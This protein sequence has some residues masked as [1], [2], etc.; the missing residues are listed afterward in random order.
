MLKQVACSW[1][2][3]SGIAGEFGSAVVAGVAAEP[4]LDAAFDEGIVQ[5]ALDRPALDLAGG[6]GVAGDD[7]RR[8]A[9]NRRDLLCDEVAPVELAEIGELALHRTRADAMAEIVLAAGI[10]LEVGRER[11][12]VPGEEA[13]QPAIMVVMAMADDQ[14]IDLGRVD[15]EDADIVEERI[16]AVAEIEQDG[17][18]IRALL[19]FEEERQTPLVVQHLAIIRAAAGPRRDMLH[20]LDGAGLEELV[21][22]G[23]DQHAQRQPVD[24][25]H[26]DRRS[27]RDLDAGEG[28]RGARR[29]S[30]GRLQERTALDPV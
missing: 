22:R 14:G 11:S 23:V 1:T 16:G 3:S 9:Q 20:A 4:V 28:A 27:T 29:K 25:R 10:E 6:E 17:A 18:R 30:G 7:G 21:M 8:L 26:L 12:A 2:C 24:G 5:D 15:L 13:V 19:G